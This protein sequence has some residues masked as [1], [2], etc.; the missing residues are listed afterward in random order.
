MTARAMLAMKNGSIRLWPVIRT[1]PAATENGT[2]PTEEKTDDNIVLIPLI[3]P[4]PFSEP[5]F[6]ILFSAM[7]YCNFITEH[8]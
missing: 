1:N 4:A 5:F 6:L 3:I 8:L 7:I 2:T